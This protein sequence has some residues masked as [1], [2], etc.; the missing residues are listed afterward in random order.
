[1]RAIVINQHGGLDELTYVEDFPDPPLG[2]GEVLVRVRAVSL[3][4][5]DIFSRRGMPGIKIPLP[6]ISGADIAGEIVA[7][8][9]QVQ[10]WALGDRVLIY[11]IDLQRSR[12][13]GE[14]S[15][16]GMCELVSVPAGLLTAIPEAVSFEQAAALPVAYGTALR[17]VKTRGRVQKDERVLIL[18]ASGG[19]GTAAVQ[20]GKILGA[21]VVACGS[22]AYK[23]QRLRE[24]GADDVID[25]VADDLVEACMKRFGKR[26]IDVV[27]NFTGGDTWVPSLKLLRYQGRLL[28]CGATAGYD[29][30]EDIRHI[31]TFELSIQGS[32]GWS[33]EDQIELLDLVAAGKLTPII[34]EVLPLADAREAERLLE[35][36][37]VF[38]KVVLV[39]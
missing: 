9:D 6:H 35:D 27:I 13:L 24:L 32:N 20:I 16:G 3:N 28:T 38:G 39:P 14:N 11:P 17:M 29:P 22:S 34:D 33:K 10:G 25:Y 21:H 8:D 5:L 36:R 37:E 31:W 30:V 7:V 23:L 12:M 19:V 15:D 26:G 2:S 1:M 4:Y 18:G